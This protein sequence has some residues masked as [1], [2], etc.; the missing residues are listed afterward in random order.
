MSWFDSF[1]DRLFKKEVQKADFSAMFQR[2]D[3]D[4]FFKSLSNLWAPNEL[5]GKLGGYHKLGLLYKDPDIYSAIDKRVAALLTTE[6][7]LEGPDESLVK[8]FEEQLRPHERQLKQDFWWTVYNGWGVEQIIYDEDGSGRVAGFQREEF[9]RFE[10]QKD[11]I[12]AKLVHSDMHNE[13][14]NQLIPYGKFVLTTN[15]GTSFNPYGDSMAER[16]IMPYIFKCNGWDLWMDFAKRFANGFM[17]GRIE[18]MEQVEEMRKALE[19][20]G[21][22]SIFVTD[23][24]TELILAQPSRD[25]SLY[26]LIDTKTV[27]SIQKVVLGETQTSNMDERGGSASAGVH[28][29]VRQEKTWADIDLVSRAINET[30]RQIGEVNGFDPKLLPT[31]TLSWDPD[32]SIEQA[33]RDN[34]LYSMG[35]R[36]TPE[37]YKRIYGLKEDDFEIVEVQSQP[38]W[39]FDSKFKKSHNG[40]SSF[41][42]PQ[43]MKDFIG[44]SDVGHKCSVHFNAD[45]ARKSRR[46]DKEK[47][48]IVELLSRNSEPPLNPDDLIAAILSSSDQKELDEKLVALFNIRNNGF[49]DDMAKGLYLAAARGAMY[50][51]PEVLKDEEE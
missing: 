31:V 29:E 26:D 9:W 39:G 10:P 18:D 23:K 49:V 5:I 14:R 17:H 46:Q 27:R 48:E 42:S 24:N 22:S 36:F 43:E 20:A 51:N 1:K 33:T 41:L 28:N 32:F 45:D 2:M 37:Y 21:K 19:A 3:F 8:F 40:K 4:M 11:L 38:S 7:Q 35:V 50:G 44:L 15:N 34:T 47:E 30:I 13:Y 25:S 6:M 12:H 16:L